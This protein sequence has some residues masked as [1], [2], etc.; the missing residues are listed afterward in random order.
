MSYRIE[1]NPEKNRIYPMSSSRKP[2]WLIVILVVVVTLFA[3]Q[4]LNRNQILKSWM[5]PGDPEVTAAAFSAMV[6]DI[7]EGVSVG[8][9]VT[10]FCLEIIDNG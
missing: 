2:K 1:Y 6:D 3:L 10:T 7:S 9:A 4:K 5:L 8:D